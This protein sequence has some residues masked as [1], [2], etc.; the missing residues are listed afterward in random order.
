[1]FKL[2]NLG[3]I[4]RYALFFPGAFESTEPFH[5]EEAKSKIISKITQ[6]GERYIVGD[7]S[8]LRLIWSSPSIS[9]HNG[10]LEGFSVHAS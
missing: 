6:R 3:M 8:P 5:E 10:C 2:P 7:F 9:V 1:M 4:K